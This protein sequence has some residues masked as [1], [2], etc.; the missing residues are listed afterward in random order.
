MERSLSQENQSL[1]TR[2][3][4]EINSVPYEDVATVTSRRRACSDRDDE[5]EVRTATEA[6]GRLSPVGLEYRNS[7]F[8]LQVQLPVLGHA[9]IW[10]SLVSPSRIVL[11]RI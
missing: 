5:N 10:Y 7:G 4:L 9:E 2:S 11:R 1:S 6:W 3:L 8:D